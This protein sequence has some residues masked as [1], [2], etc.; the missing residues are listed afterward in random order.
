MTVESPGMLGEFVSGLA[1]LITIGYLA[2]RT[3]Q[4]RR[5]LEQQ[6]GQ[7]VTSFCFPNGDY[8]PTALE[9]VR[10]NYDSAVSTEYGWNTK[11][12]DKHLLKRIGIHEDVA[13]D[14][15][16]FLARISGWLSAFRASS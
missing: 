6:T 12:S 13:A 10:H 4:T 15:T 1:V 7:R 11:A 14:K 5:M 8:S 2:Y 9:L 3:Q 16:A